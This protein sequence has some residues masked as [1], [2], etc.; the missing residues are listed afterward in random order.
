MSDDYISKKFRT[1]VPHELNHTGVIGADKY[2]VFGENKLRVQVNFTGIGTLAIQARINTGEVWTNIGEVSSSEPNK[3]FDISTY[4]YVRFDFIAPPG[5]AGEVAASGFFSQA[6]SAVTVETDSGNIDTANTGSILK[7]KGGSDIDTEIVGDEIIIN[8]TAAAGAGLSAYSDDFVIGEWVL[9][10][11]VYSLTYLET[12]HNLGSEVDIFVYDFD[13][14]L[15]T[16]V[17]TNKI[18]ASNG[19]VTIEVS[20]SP[21]NRFNGRIHIKES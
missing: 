5:S 6:G 14:S 19:D 12:V 13:G 16:E 9:G 7:I 11:G 1:L 15:Y 3:T 2:P 4:D 21:D 18:V 10:A 20:S 8:S 17:E